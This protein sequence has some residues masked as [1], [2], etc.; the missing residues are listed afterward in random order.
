MFPDLSRMLVIRCFIPLFRMFATVLKPLNSF[1]TVAHVNS[2][3]FCICY[4]RACSRRA[5]P[6]PVSDSG[7]SDSGPNG[8]PT[9]YA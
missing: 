2:A 8:W 3:F 7:C 9:S 5:F 1:T 6:R 4:A